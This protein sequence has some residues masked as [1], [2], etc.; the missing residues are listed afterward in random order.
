MASHPGAVD[1]CIG[2][3]EQKIGCNGGYL[4]SV[5]AYKRSIRNREPGLCNDLGVNE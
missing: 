3:K 2:A 1:K 4:S 5:D